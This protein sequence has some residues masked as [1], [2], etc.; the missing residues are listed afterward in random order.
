MIA[1][2]SIFIKPQRRV[3]GI[4]HYNADL[5]SQTSTH[6]A[7][8]ISF[9]RA[10]DTACEPNL[11]DYARSHGLASDH[12]QHDHFENI[13]L[14]LPGT[15]DE[16]HAKLFEI[17]AQAVD[18]LQERLVT[19]KNVA[20]ILAT[21]T[22]PP[23]TSLRFDEDVEPN[24]N[25]WQKLKL[26]LP[27]LKTDHEG[28]LRQFLRPHNPSLGLEHLPLEGLDEE[29]DE[30]L[31]WPS[32]CLKLGE[33]IEHQ[34]WTDKLVISKD[35]IGVLADV[36]RNEPSDADLKFDTENVPTYKRVHSHFP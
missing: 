20:Q 5:V 26:E 24:T 12:R 22:R 35:A 34:C 2:H 31:G 17:E 28:D 11:L 21:I 15:D 32:Y 16:D 30:G 27:I 14:E 25:K 8:L 6:L 3:V 1:P 18:P 4:F 13:Y 23:E 33:Q 10:M 29:L 9:C 7:R 19:D 36:V